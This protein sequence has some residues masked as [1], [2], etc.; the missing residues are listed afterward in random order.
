MDSL[1]YFDETIR[2]ILDKNLDISVNE[3]KNTYSEDS[4]FVSMLKNKLDNFK[5]NYCLKLNYN[6]VSINALCLANINLDIPYQSDIDFDYICDENSNSY[7]FRYI[8][9]NLRFNKEDVVIVYLNIIL[10]EDLNAFKFMNF[11]FPYNCYHDVEIKTS[12]EDLWNSLNNS[13]YCK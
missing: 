13:N 5:A 1:S 7:F 6:K 8:R 2:K 9:Q 3:Y 10:H 11:Y 4:E 12:E